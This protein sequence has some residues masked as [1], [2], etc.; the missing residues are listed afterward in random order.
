M[1]RDLRGTFFNEDGCIARFSYL[2]GV[3]LSK[4]FQLLTTFI[5]KTFPNYHF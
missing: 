2:H 1:I 3:P 4:L 5:S